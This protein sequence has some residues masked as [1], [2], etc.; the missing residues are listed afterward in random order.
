MKIQESLKKRVAKVV[1]LNYIN[2]ED[3]KNLVEPLRSERGEI[4]VPKKTDAF[5]IPETAPT[6]KDDYALATSI[7]VIDYEDNV[8]AIEKLC[9]HKHFY[10]AKV[11][12]M[13]LEEFLR[14]GSSVEENKAPSCPL[15][16]REREVLQLLAEGN[17]NKEVGVKLS[18]SVKTVE[19]HRAHIMSKL[20]LH[21]MSDL[22]RYAI[23]N[24]FIQP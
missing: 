20:N 5:I 8:A 12:E 24:Q 19:T 1:Y 4:R 9:Q 22:V 3:A 6:G 14:T 2:A 17:T 21:S 16:T 10:T 23:R 15:T 7:V 11:N 18:I 13:M